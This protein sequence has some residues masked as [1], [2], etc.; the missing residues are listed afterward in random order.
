VGDVHTLLLMLSSVGFALLA[1]LTAIYLRD[2]YPG[3]AAVHRD[4]DRAEG[5]VAE[6]RD[7]YRQEID[8]CFEAQLRAVDE[9]LEQAIEARHTLNAAVREARQ[10]IASYENW[11]RAWSTC[12]QLLLRVYWIA[13]HRT[14]NRSMPADKSERSAPQLELVTSPLIEEVGAAEVLL[15]RL[16]DEVIEQYRREAADT[17]R[18][19]DR[20]H[21]AVQSSAPD[22]FRQVEVSTESVGPPLPPLALPAP[23]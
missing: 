3:Y 20:R 2:P 17:Q 8:Q 4:H 18:E 16:T 11:V 13:Y 10:M 5:Q 19:L 23:A 15:D 14:L 6:E 9:R 21:T 22:F 12:G 7:T 1:M